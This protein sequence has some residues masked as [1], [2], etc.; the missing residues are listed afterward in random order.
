MSKQ[1]KQINRKKIKQNCR[2]SWQS[3][4][5]P[6]ENLRFSSFFFSLSIQKWYYC[7]YR[8][9]ERINP[10]EK[11]NK[12]KSLIVASKMH[13]MYGRWASRPGMGRDILWKR[14]D[15]R[16]REVR[17]VDR[18]EGIHRTRTNEYCIYT[19]TTNMKI[20]ANYYGINTELFAENYN[21]G[22]RFFAWFCLEITYI[23]IWNAI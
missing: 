3:W 16:T 20:A 2:D 18:V 23:F 5:A 6:V 1:T 21:E 15:R 4:W 8:M 10:F 13:K 9:Y 14:Q 11:E 19:H 22:T 12:W 17:Q 7:A